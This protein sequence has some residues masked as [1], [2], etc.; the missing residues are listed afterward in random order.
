MSGPLYLLD[1][2]CFIQ[3][4]RMTYPLDVATS[5]WAKLK[6]LADEGT[7]SSI[8]KVK[9]ELG[10]NKDALHL[11]C[12]ANL[13][14]DFFHSSGSVMADYAR[15][16]QTASRRIPPYSQSALS[17]FFDKDEADAWLIAHALQKGL[18]IVTHEVS[19]PAGI[20]N[21][22]IPDI[23]NLLGVRTLITIAM[24]RELNEQF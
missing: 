18:P 19:Q 5:F 13:Q 16:I 8:D 2:N 10:R 3:A 17:T 24:F 7:I 9:G 11:W 6:Q 12:A 15:V 22:K 1:S 23:C 20:A 4:H 21:V 14:P